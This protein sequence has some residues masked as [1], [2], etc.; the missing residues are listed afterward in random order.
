MFHQEPGFF[1]RAVAAWRG[2]AIAVAYARLGDHHLAQDAAQMAFVAAFQNLRKLR[3]PAAF[4]AWL[5]RI[6]ISQCHRI[7]RKH[8][9]PERSL[10]SNAIEVAAGGPDPGSVCERRDLH[11]RLQTEVAALPAAQRIAVRLYYSGN[12]STAGIARQLDLPLTTVKKRLHDARRRLRQRMA[13]G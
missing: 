2:N 6:T 11:R 1:D 9:I 5:R 7:T 10:D 12:C 4:P 13:E 3:D 8:R